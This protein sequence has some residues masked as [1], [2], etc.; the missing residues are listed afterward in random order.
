M[1]LKFSSRNQKPGESAEDFSAELKRLYDKAHSGRDWT[2]RREDL[3]R[4]FLDG[5]TDGKTSQQVE[6]VRDPKDIDSAV[7][8]VV[9]YQDTRRQSTGQSRKLKRNEQSGE[10]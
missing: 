5:L 7:Y 1:T 8:K 2:I 10:I 9:S 3:L 4:R 6:F